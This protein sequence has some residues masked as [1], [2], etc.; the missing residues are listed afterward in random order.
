MLTNTV[1]VN[2]AFLHENDRT[3]YKIVLIPAAEIDTID[4]FLFGDPVM[5]H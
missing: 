4:A 3:E 2:N 1:N 5:S